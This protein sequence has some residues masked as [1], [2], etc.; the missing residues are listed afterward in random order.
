MELY[1]IRRD[2][3]LAGLKAGVSMGENFGEYAKAS[4]AG[5]LHE[6]LLTTNIISLSRAQL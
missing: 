1:F 6:S 4:V 5:G 3:C 2:N